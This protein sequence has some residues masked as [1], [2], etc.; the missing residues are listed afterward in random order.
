MDKGED[1]VAGIRT[2][3]DLD[4]M[5]QSMPEAYNKLVENCKILERHYKDMMASAN[6]SSRKW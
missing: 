6:F 4:T 3:E 1:V 5:K 2:L